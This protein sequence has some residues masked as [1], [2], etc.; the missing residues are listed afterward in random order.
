MSEN[1]GGFTLPVGFFLF[2]STPSNDGYLGALLVTDSRGLPLEFRCT[3]PVKPTAI[4]KLL[5][6]A[7]LEPHV[8]V[9]LC[10]VPLMESTR[11]SLCLLL[12]NRG[13]LL[14]IR[15]FAKCPVVYVTAVREPVKEALAELK[16]DS[17]SE[18]VL[19]LPIGNGHLLKCQWHSSYAD[20]KGAIVQHLTE[21]QGHF[22][23]IEPFERVT[24]ALRF[25]QEHDKRFT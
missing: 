20:D 3:A 10:G 5:Y 16:P 24:A 19:D 9:N 12:V 15:A 11:N 23:P 13:Y 18:A 7:H 2:S 21:C 25:L 6:G 14:P 8:A 22:D 1:Q 4:Q 17:P